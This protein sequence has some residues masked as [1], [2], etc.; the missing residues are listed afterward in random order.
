MMLYCLGSCIVQ[1][2]SIKKSNM[3][4][5]E[6]KKQFRMWILY[7]YF[8]HFDILSIMLDNSHNSLP[9]LLFSGN[10]GQC[11]ERRS[12]LVLEAIIQ[13]FFLFTVSGSLDSVLIH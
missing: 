10:V 8:F 3:I 1:F 11:I 12:N 4:R 7:I 6:K 2:S 9:L 5:M 13:L